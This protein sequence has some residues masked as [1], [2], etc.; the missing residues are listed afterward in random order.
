MPTQLSEER[1]GT[2]SV[3]EDRMTQEGERAVERKGAKERTQNR[4]ET[5]REKGHKISMRTIWF[6]ELL[7]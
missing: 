6:H 1:R 5:R 4:K 7:K 3:N 2:K